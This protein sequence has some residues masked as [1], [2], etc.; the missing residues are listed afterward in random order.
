MLRSSGIRREE[1]E[2]RG[3]LEEIEEEV[4]RGK[5]RGKIG[6]LWALVGAVNAMRERTGGGDGS[7]RGEWAVVDEDGVAQIAQVCKY[8]SQSTVIHI[9]NPA[10]RYC[11]SSKR[12]SYI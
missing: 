12:A 9:Y 3:E 7:G 10:Y 6:E 1:E 8:Y 11:R 2:L 5:G 4:K